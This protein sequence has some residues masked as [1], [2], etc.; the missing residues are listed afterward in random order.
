[1]ENLH[2]GDHA[3]LFYR[4]R[5]EQFAVIV[6]F[7]AIGLKRG[8][9]C[10][11]IADDNSVAMIIDEL[12]KGGVD[13][14]AMQKSG[15]LTIAT[16]HETYLRHGIFEPAKMTDDLAHEVN[17]SIRLGYTAFR[18]AGEMTWALTLPYALAQLS[19][20]E[21]RLHEQ[22]PRQF[23]AL[24]QYNERGFS[25]RVI[26]DMIRIHPV[27]VARGKLLQNRFHQPGATVETLLPD[28]VT[29]DELVNTGTASQ[30][31]LAC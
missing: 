22:M 5:A 12:E 10:M 8:E 4:T 7:I 19:D 20:Y 1:M 25:E 6:P 15:A 30:T 14:L 31:A 23:V 28:I 13:V 18:A 9:R 21:T 24:C 16:K 26:A 17:E 29:V 27:V 11:Y 3:A 2:A